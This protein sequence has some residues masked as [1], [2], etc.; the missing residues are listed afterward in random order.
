MMSPELRIL[1]ASAVTFRDLSTSPDRGFWTLVRRPLLLMLAM[2]L[3]LSLASSTRVSARVVIDGMISFAFLPLA[4]A[5]AVGI[6]YLRGERRL[7]L[8]QVVDMFFVTNSPWLLWILAFCVWQSAARTP[9]I[10]PGGV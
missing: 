5:L 4:E 8:T 1:R 9:T 3:V 10:L 7:P 2:G 6:V